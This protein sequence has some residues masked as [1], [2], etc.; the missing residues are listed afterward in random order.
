MK[1]ILLFAACAAFVCSAQA[2]NKLYYD[3]ENRAE[4]RGVSPS[5]NYA[6]FT[7][8]DNNVGYL[9]S[10]ENPEVF[11]PIVDVDTQGDIRFDAYDVND[12]GIVVGSIQKEDGSRVY[13][14]PAVWQNGEFTYLPVEL[15][16]VDET[17]NAM[18][19]NLNYA[20]RISANGQIVGGYIGS[21][22]SLPSMGYPAYPV[23]WEK[24]DDGSWEFHRYNNIQ[25][26]DHQG[27]WVRTMY[28]DGTLEGTIL[29]GILNCAA[30]SMVPA[31]LKDGELVYW[32]K[33]EIREFE[34]DTKWGT[35]A[36]EYDFIDGFKDGW[37]YTFFYGGFYGSD[38]SGNFYGFKSSTHMPDD[39]SELP[40]DGEVTI[41]NGS[42][43]YNVFTDEWTYNIGQN[44]YINGIYNEVFFTANGQMIVEGKTESPLS[45][46]GVDSQAG[47]IRFAGVTQTS[48][49]GNVLAGQHNVFNDATLQDDPFPVIIVLDNAM[50]GVDEIA[51]GSQAVSVRGMK[52]CID[53]QGAENV[54]VYDMQGRYMGNGSSLAPGIYV[55][56][57]DDT[58]AKVIVK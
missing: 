5:G 56:K 44:G 37:D 22:P 54:A 49:K 12:D 28:S 4:A 36:F 8:P 11:A 15:D 6:V 29:G 43:V 17:G 25:L 1:K 45:Y 30:G 7:D 51:T 21:R 38:N 16:K 57:A 13:W 50:V 32:N 53:V 27:F 9:W 18:T 55:V 39:G 10:R 14:Q 24:K 46:F 58:T 20:V 19:G 35:M 34:E 42:C 31:L 41:D 52:G 26:P 47:G 2:E 23:I 48:D 33:L 3:T 40:Y